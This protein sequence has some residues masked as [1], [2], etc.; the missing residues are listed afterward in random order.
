MKEI[1]LTDGLA[2]LVDD[3]DYERLARYKWSVAWGSW[4]PYA[5][6]RV[7]GKRVLMHRLLTNAPAGYEVDHV[8][9]HSLDNRRGNLRVVTRQENLAKRRFGLFARKQSVARRAVRA[10]DGLVSRGGGSLAL[11]S[12]VGGS[13][14]FAATR[15]T[16]S[17]DHGPHVHAHAD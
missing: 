14:G 8:N 17:D 6:A 4:Y 13:G 2:A 7:D 15:A 5:Q 3:E 12:D 10:A 1:P 16:N 9:G 11:S